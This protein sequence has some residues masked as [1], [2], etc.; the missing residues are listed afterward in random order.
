MPCTHHG[1]SMEGNYLLRVEMYTYNEV[2]QRHLN[3]SNNHVLTYKRVFLPVIIHNR[4][5]P[6]FA[7]KH[8]KN[9]HSQIIVLV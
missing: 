8:A 7:I 3:T 5:W 1:P 9:L 2:S 6:Y 4:L